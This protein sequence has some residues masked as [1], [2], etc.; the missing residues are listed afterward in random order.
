[1]NVIRHRNAQNRRRSFSLIELLVVVAI[2]AILAAMLLPALNG[3]RES[4]KSAACMGN[5]RQIIEAMMLYA[6]DYAGLLP[7]QSTG[8]I[9][10]SGLLTNTVVHIPALFR[11]PSDRNERRPIFAGCAW[12][13]Y[14]VNSGK[15]TLAAVGYRCPWPTNGPPAKLADVPQPVFLLSEN[16]GVSPSTPPYNTG[17]IVGVAEME[18][19]DGLASQTHRSGANYG[20]R[21]GRVEYLAKAYIDQWRADTDYS[22]QPKEKGDPWKWK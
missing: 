12:R 4:A 7:P 17:A 2:I 20:L 9:D 13:S 16:H 18:G 5:L 11:C 8:T 6:D 22:G 1:M 3:A 14:A 15:F 19:I 21:D 10:W